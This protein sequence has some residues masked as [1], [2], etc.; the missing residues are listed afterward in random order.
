MT[1]GNLLNLEATRAAGPFEEKLFIDCVDLEYCLRLRKEGFVI[2]QD[3][4]VPLEHSLGDF[5]TWKFLGLKIGYSNHN[6]VR[7]YY[8][9]RNKIYV[10]RKYF[11]SD[12]VFS[13]LVIRSMAGDVVRIVFFEKQKIS[14]LRSMLFG[15]RDAVTGHY[16]KY[17]PKGIQ[18]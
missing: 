14:K 5:R 15:C 1:S 17:V 9:T 10:L 8:I 12:P 16:G 13:W 4:T 18:L 2:I 6:P 3:N 11:R 7:R